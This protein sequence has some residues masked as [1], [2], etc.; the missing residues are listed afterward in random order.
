[1]LLFIRRLNDSILSWISFVKAVKQL[2]TFQ[3]RGTARQLRVLY[4]DVHQL[5]QT[6]EETLRGDYSC[7]LV[8]TD[9]SAGF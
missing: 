3:K 6:G 8:Y 9:M 7:T 4:E 1:M 2:Q 5:V